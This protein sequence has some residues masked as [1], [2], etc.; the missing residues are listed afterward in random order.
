MDTAIQYQELAKFVGTWNTTG[1]VLATKTSAE[2]II[3]GTDTYE[4]LPGKFFLLHKAAVWMGNDK[5]ETFEIIGADRNKQLFTMQYYDNKGNSGSMTAT[6]VDGVW[7]YLGDT[8]QFNGCF[9]NNDKEFSGIWKQSTDGESW[10]HI[11]DI[12]LVKAES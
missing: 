5:S 12:K 7:T 2:I 3:S 8:L 11:M 4:W 10:T 1:R 6:Y 9:K